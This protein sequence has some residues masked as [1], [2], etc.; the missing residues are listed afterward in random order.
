M[1]ELEASRLGTVETYERAI[2]CCDG[3]PIHEWEPGRLLD[4]IALVQMQERLL[5]DVRR[6]LEQKHPALAEKRLDDYFAVQ[7]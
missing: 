1:T 2:V 4:Y 5:T 3:V 7:P 6:D